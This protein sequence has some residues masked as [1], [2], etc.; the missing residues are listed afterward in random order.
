MTNHEIIFSIKSKNIKL[1][2]R[3]H[4]E[5][6][7]V[8]C[9]ENRVIKRKLKFQS[10]KNCLE[11][12]EIER[13]IKY[14]ENKKFNIDIL[15]E[16]QK[17]LKNNKLILKTQQRFKSERHNLFNEE[18]NKISLSWNNHKWMGSIDLIETCVYGTSKD[19]ICKI[20]KIKCNNITII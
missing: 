11:A 13:K 19:L 8:K 5:D 15:K 17:E 6:K 12:A 10:Y 18:I 4:D 9:R 2:K 3:S 20:V 16:D 1:F 14:L 7:K